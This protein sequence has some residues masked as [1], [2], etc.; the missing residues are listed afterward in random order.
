MLHK[1]YING[2]NGLNMHDGYLLGGLHIFGVLFF[3]ALIAAVIYLIVKVKKQNSSKNET[4]VKIKDDEAM[5][6]LRQRYAKGEIDFEEYSKL[7][8]T[9]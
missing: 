1:F 9:L 2:V 4:I 5:S 7:K 6:I 8:E 3:A